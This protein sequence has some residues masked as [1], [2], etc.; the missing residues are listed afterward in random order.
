MLLMIILSL[1]RYSFHGD[2]SM[3]RF[4]LVI[5]SLFIMCSMTITAHANLPKS[6]VNLKTKKSTQSKNIK[7]KKSIKKSTKKSPQK[8]NT[9]KLKLTCMQQ[10]KKSKNRN[11]CISQCLKG[12]NKNQSLQEKE[13][14]PRICCKALTASCLACAEGVTVQEYC[15]THSKTA[16]CGY[17]FKKKNPKIKK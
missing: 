6:T 15:K 1:K 4:I 14:A 7:S 16:E 12:S 9:S 8:L 13:E 17:S 11:T 10:C 5:L 3:H 2:Q